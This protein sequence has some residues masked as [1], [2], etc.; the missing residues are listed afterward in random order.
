MDTLN[1]RNINKPYTSLFSYNR[2]QSILNYI[3]I[4]NYW[5]ILVIE[6]SSHTNARKLPTSRKDMTIWNDARDRCFDWNDC[7]KTCIKSKYIEYERLKIL[8]R[9]ITQP[10]PK[11]PLNRNPSKPNLVPLCVFICD[12][13]YISG[14]LK[15]L[16]ILKVDSN[17]L[18]ELTNQIG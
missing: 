15:K 8:F 16:G 4:R 14:N 2:T 3:A 13:L 9:K 6:N 5:S 7:V 10:F 1:N 11:T 18:I 17:R 12:V